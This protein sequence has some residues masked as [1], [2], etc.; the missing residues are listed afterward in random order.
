MKDTARVTLTSQLTL[1]R[2][3]SI[4][5]IMKYEWPIEMVFTLQEPEAIGEV[6]CILSYVVQVFTESA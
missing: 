1:L 3:R 5:N 4:S 2:L 6:Q